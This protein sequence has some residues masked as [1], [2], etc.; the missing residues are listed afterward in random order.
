MELKKQLMHFAINKAIL[1]KFTF[2]DELIACM[3][4]CVR[5]HVRARVC[6]YACAPT[7]ESAHANNFESVKYIPMTSKMQM[8]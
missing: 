1:F 5:A 4:V 7:R 2:W 8:T 3:C 6:A